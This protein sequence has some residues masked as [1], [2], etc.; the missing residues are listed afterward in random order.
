[1]YTNWM[2]HRFIPAFRAKFPQK[3]CILVFDNAGYH[4]AIGENYMKL[5]GTKLELIEKLKKLAVNSISV[6][7]EGK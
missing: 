6:E 4:H 2:R 5:G 1:M 7:R 3:K